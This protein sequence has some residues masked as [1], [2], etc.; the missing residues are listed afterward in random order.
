M[1]E[2]YLPDSVYGEQYFGK[3]T[4]PP[5]ELRRDVVWLDQ[6][7]LSVKIHATGDRSAREA[8]DAI[9]HARQVSG[10]YQPRHEIS[11]AQFIHPAD[12][13][14]FAAL[15]VAAEMCPI[16]W[17][18]TASDGARE[19]VLGK[20]RAKKMWPMRSLIDQGATVFY[21]SDWPAVVPN[22]NPWPGI[23]AM[24]T[25]RNPYTDGIE[26]QWPEQAVSLIEALRIVTVNGAATGGS[27]NNSGSIEVGKLAD[28][29]VLD[30]NLFE[31]PETEISETQVL[32]TV[33]NGNVIH[34]QRAVD[35]H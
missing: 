25:R 27:R 7:G 28:F 20:D 10:N 17:Y 22:T 9:A 5:D 18:P 33:V 6:Q 21:G 13:P 23:E 11:H 4:L 15:N 32:M 29:I 30:R 26:A 1:L 14:R 24:V 12:M 3:M 31:V 34:D 35:T 16:L 8:L 2:P 19:A